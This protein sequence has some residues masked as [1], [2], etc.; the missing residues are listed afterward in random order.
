MLRLF[1]E[2]RSREVASLD[3][4]WN[5]KTDRDGVGEAEAWYLG[6]RDFEKVSVPS[7]WNTDLKLL[8][9]EGA[10]WYEREFYFS[11]GTLRLNFGAVMTEGKVWL[12]GNLLGSHYGGFTRFDF[13]V[14]DVAEG[15]HR[16][17]VRADNSFDKRSIPQV[18]VD[19]YHYGGIIRGVD[20]ERLVGI[21]VLDQHLEYE[22]DL[23]SRSAE[24]RV[25][26]KLYNADGVTRGSAVSTYVG[27]RIGYADDVELAAYESAEILS[28]PFLI[29]DIELWDIGAGNLYDLVTITEYDDLRDRVGFRKI[30]VGCEEL[31]LNG[32][33]IEIRGVNRHE[34]HPDWGFAFPTGLMK[35]DLDIVSD[36]G[37]NSIRG[38][39]YPMSKIFLDMLDERGILFWSEIPMWGWGFSV[40]TLADEVVV[41]RGLEMHR[42]MVRDYYNHPA[43]IIWGM[44]NEIHTEDPVSIPLSKKYYEYLKAEGGNRIVTFATDKPLEDLCLEYCDLISI[45]AYHGW[46]AGGIDYWA[47][48]LGRVRERRD[49]LGYGNKPV[50]FSEFG[51]A[52]LYGYHTFDDVQWTEEYQAR[53]LT[54]AIDLFHQDDMCIG[55]YIWQMNDIRTC[56]EAGINRARGFNNKGILNEYRRPKAAYFAVK[57]LYCKYKPSWEKEK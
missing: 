50:I 25:M 19:W 41:E 18:K 26:L 12:D 34:E 57:E 22:L 30:E 14:S 43:I 8:G 4:I 49:S 45:N 20:A 1:D 23:E 38:S 52:A 46:Y 2:H 33:A 24:C 47:E 54:H 42:E 13:I 6:L 48:F 11:G 53:L 3:G 17:T 16:L 35:R 15:R 10:A 27:E 32:R 36:L 55:F 9:Y 56:I 51:A 21:S 39:H 29:E 40:K 5:F 7:V 44:H 37:C 31:L 28:E